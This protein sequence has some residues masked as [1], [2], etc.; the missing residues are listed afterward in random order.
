M[1]K[2]K[3]YFLSKIIAIV[4]S[5]ACCT[6]VVAPAVLAA[7]EDQVIEVTNPGDTVQVPLT[8]NVEE[9]EPT[10]IFSAT[11][12]A[13]IPI[14]YKSDD[15]SVLVANGAKIQN[16]ADRSIQVTDLTVGMDNGWT[17]VPFNTDLS[18]SDG[19]KKVGLKL[20]S[21]LV[22]Q[23]GAVN[24]TKSDWK[25]GPNSSLPIN[26]QVNLPKKISLQTTQAT[27]DPADS[28]EQF[29]TL[30]FTLD[31][32]EDDAPIPVTH[33]VNI[34]PGDHGT[35]QN[36][37]SFTV[38]DQ[39]TLTLPNVIPDTGYSLEKWIDTANGQTVTNQT[40]VTSD[41]T[42]QPVFTPQTFMVT[43]QAG[44]YGSLAGG[45][46]SKQVGYGSTTTFPTPVPAPN[47]LFD[48][49]VDQTGKTVTSDT[50]F[51]SSM[52]I[53]AQFR[54]DVTDPAYFNIDS[55]GYITGFSDAYMNLADKPTIL[56]FPSEINNIRVKGIGPFA[57]ACTTP[58]SS[59]EQNFLYNGMTKGK[60][61]AV[62]NA[63]SEIRQ[64]TL[65]ASVDAYT[66]DKFA[67][68]G[69]RKLYSVELNEILRIEQN[70]FTG[71]NTLMVINLGKV[72]SIGQECFYAC[73]LLSN[74]DLG[75]IDYSRNLGTSSFGDCS[76]LTAADKEQ[77]NNINPNALTGG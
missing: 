35:I 44:P 74:I 2:T 8:I 71:C 36:S 27:T 68:Y 12:S 32:A 58:G 70:A 77:I 23:V 29:A 7:E 34:I 59:M 19:Q 31:W 38:E 60:T 21:D 65:P 17:L 39:Q 18:Q 66:I 4:L 50:A 48:K 55:D 51:T 72:T 54:E 24:I 76:R 11:V 33:T 22:A 61:Q 1:N 53:T 56:K 63:N 15:G 25:I 20:R 3:K 46:T 49:W 45:N 41:L 13:E 52:T 14:S 16:N 75:S 28:I 62:Y 47:Y 67:F 40:K 57:F 37:E 30:R 43:F 64:V 5:A 42:I 69:C 73:S 6:G 10:N 9:P 26:M